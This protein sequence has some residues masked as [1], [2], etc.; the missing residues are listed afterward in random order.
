MLVLDT[1]EIARYVAAGR[2]RAMTVD[3]AQLEPRRIADGEGHVIYS[4]LAD[5]LERHPYSVVN[6]AVVVVAFVTGIDG[7][8]PKVLDLNRC[9]SLRI[10]EGRSESEH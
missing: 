8:I 5:V 9:R 6:N 7:N 3:D 2:E 4:P 1:A 10:R